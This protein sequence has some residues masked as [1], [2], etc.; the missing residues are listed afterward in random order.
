MLGGLDIVGSRWQIANLDS[1]AAAAG[2][3]VTLNS[4]NT[5]DNA[6]IYFP[7][8]DPGDTRSGSQGLKRREQSISLEFTR[9]EPD[10]SLEVF[11]TFSL[12]E[13]YSRYGKLSWFVTGFDVEDDAGGRDGAGLQYFVR[14]A[15]DERGANYYE[16]RAPLP[17]ASSPRALAWQEVRLGLTE[18][19]S[20][21][22]G[23]DFPAGS[24]AI[25]Y[26]RART[27]G[28]PETLIV[29][30][31]PSFTRLR[32]VS[33]GL[34]SSS[35]ART[36]RRGQMWFDELRAIE[37]AKDRGR[38]QRVLANGSLANLLRYNLSWNGRDADFLSVGEARGSGNSASDLSVGTTLDL[39]RFF[40]ETGIVLPVSFNF[41]QRS[42]QPRFT[43]GDDVVRS[44]A[45]SAASE[46][47][48][49]GR[50]WQ[51]SYQRSWSERSNPLLRYTI[52]GITAS[53]G[54]SNGHGHN[55]NSLDRNRQ[56]QAQVNYQVSPRSLLALRLPATRVKFHPLPERFFW[57]YNRQDSEGLTV[58]RLSGG[59]SLLARAKVIGRAAT[60]RFGADS[61]PF[62]I[63][64]HSF[65]AERNLRLANPLL[66]RI[67]I[68]NLGRV[69]RWNQSMNMRYGPNFG[70]WIKPTFTWRSNYNQENGPELSPDLALRSIRNGQSV[71]VTWGLPFDVLVSRA[72][73]RL[74]GGA[75]RTAPAAGKDSGTVAAP[76]VPVWRDV[77]SR[78]GSLSTETAFNWSSAYSRLTG[79]PGLAYLTGFSSSP[80]PG[81]TGVQ[82]GFGNTSDRS[83]DWR[84][85]GQTR[86]ALV[87]G[88]S[89]T[90][91]AEFARQFS[92]RNDVEQRKA[93]S[94]F[95][96][97]Q[98]DYG[99]VA[100]AI[101]LD[102]VLR[103]PRLRTAFSRSRTSDFSGSRQTG[104][105][106]SSQWQPMLSAEGSL[107]SGAKLETKVER[108][109]TRRRD[110]R[111]SGSTQTDR[112]TNLSFG[113]TRSYSQGQRVSFL[114]RET[115][116]KSTVSLA[117]ST[118][119]SR[120][121]GE[122]IRDDDPLKRPISPRRIDDLS[123]LG[124][125][126]Y[127]FSNN[128]TGNLSLGF[129]QNRDLDRDIVTRS[130][131]VELAARFSF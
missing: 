101:G 24:G 122:T 78:L 43:A 50:S 103:T 67:G 37:V 102:R 99:R 86:L 128:V 65:S 126:S 9:L 118:T 116:V 107:K 45:Q 98:V 75:D 129:N 10:S 58:D 123:A 81:G 111:L 19:S 30:G 2:T 87:L 68:V 54:G 104:E 64:Q 119:Y 40:E 71:N 130:V 4:V 95:P 63:F 7:P 96:D 97:F 121:T 100:S 61:R 92:N 105:S 70:T 21:K 23:D 124:T 42:S 38:A 17:V 66:E 83:Y 72:P 113:L 47:F 117:L 79:T 22:L 88:A 41:Y 53:L 25:Y 3:S 51:T 82:T 16:F 55:P 1:S 84:T 32:R 46:T 110:L 39:H 115:T 89:V 49:D 34:V 91:S 35:G 26:Q 44:G 109:V 125:G 85:R 114:G 20:L 74:S 112:T 18:L 11:K 77:L 93:N 60:V 33:F 14:L 15:S 52:G 73:S 12:D 13:N 31:R 69:V 56:L 76:R 29:K 36:F 94:R 59:D 57:N 5:V 106:I 108:R 27:D 120:Q 48:S 131:R 6:E 80:E 28:S 62:E 90:T 127:G 8:F